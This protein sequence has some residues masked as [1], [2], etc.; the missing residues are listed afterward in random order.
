MLRKFLKKCAPN[1]FECDQFRFKIY[2]IIIYERKH[3]EVSKGAFLLN[4]KLR[5]PC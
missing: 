5:I 4:I 1:I 2:M 3:S